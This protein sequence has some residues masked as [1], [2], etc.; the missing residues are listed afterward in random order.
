MFFNS[1]AQ[2]LRTAAKDR[3]ILEPGLKE[4][5]VERNKQLD[6]IFCWKIIDGRPVV[7]YTFFYYKNHVYKNVEAQMTLKFKKLFYFVV[8]LLSRIEV[9][10]RKKVYQ[11]R[12][13]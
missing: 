1:V 11:A 8:I 13:L 6:D 7:R 4:H 5:I 9:L 10:I 2:W 12:F 3:G